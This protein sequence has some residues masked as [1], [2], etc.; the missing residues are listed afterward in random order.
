[1]VVNDLGPGLLRNLYVKIHD[2]HGKGSGHWRVQKQQWGTDLCII[3]II[4]CIQPVWFIHGKLTIPAVT[5]HGNGVIFA[6]GRRRDVGSTWKRRCDK[7]FQTWHLICRQHSKSKGHFRKSLITNMYFNMDFTWNPGPWP[8]ACPSNHSPWYWL[9]G[10]NG[11]LLA[12][13]GD[14]NSLCHLSM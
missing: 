11:S 1:M 3:V 12:T 10:I 7:D 6:S 13:M 2:R 14:F 9:Y 4:S 5:W 8:I